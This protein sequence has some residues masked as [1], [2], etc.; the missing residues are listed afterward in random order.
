VP[1][2]L[3]AVGALCTVAAGTAGGWELAARWVARARR[4]ADLRSALALLETEMAVGRTPLPEAAAHVAALAPGSAVAHFFRDVAGEL[5]RGE[6]AD[7]A[8][9]AS[10][11]ALRPTP[12]GLGQLSPQLGAEEAAD[13][14]PLLLLAGVIGATDLA[15]QL[16]HLGLARERLAGREAQAAEV[17]RRLAPVYRYAGLAVGVLVALLL[18]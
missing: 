3:K 16:K 8:W 17:A 5:A 12:D 13:L 4:L 18:V 1:V 10:A 15:D 14:E 2:W 6:P 11:A 7:R 9:R